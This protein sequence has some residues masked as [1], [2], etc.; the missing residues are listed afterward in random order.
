MSELGLQDAEGR[1]IEYMGLTHVIAEAIQQ[2][3]DN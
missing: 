3:Q 2:L 1:G